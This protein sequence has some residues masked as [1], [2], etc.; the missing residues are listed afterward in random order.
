MAL[1]RCDITSWTLKMDTSLTVILPQD[2]VTQF[3]PEPAPPDPAPPVLYLLHGA[4]DDS[5]AWARFT[6]IERYVAPLGLAVVMP[7]VGR[8]FYVDQVHGQPFGTFLTEEL[9]QI[10]HSMFR[11]SSRREDTFVAG[12]SMGGYGALRWAL[13]RPDRFAAA[14]SF[15]APLDIVR[16]RA[17]REP[18]R[19][20]MLGAAFG[21]D[22]LAGSPHDLFRLLADVAGSATTPPALFVGCGT[23]DPLLPHSEQFASAAT[24]LGLPVTTSYSPGEH[25]WAYW[26]T[27]LRELLAWLPLAER[28]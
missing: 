9:P 18:H 4:G 7:Q 14:G 13:S 6:A 20:P 28:P 16:V 12:L 25:A 5:T 19:E 17:L 15:S 27:A 22:D 2:H 21:E 1:L 26:D 3:S 23:E 11:L 24:E 8:S 10:V